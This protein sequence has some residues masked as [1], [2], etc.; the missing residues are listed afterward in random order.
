MTKPD[1]HATLQPWWG[2]CILAA[3]TMGRWHIGPLILWAQRLA[4]EWR[5]AWR[6]GE[7]LMQPVA[8]VEMSLPIEKPAA[9]M[10]VCRFSFRETGKPLRLVPA[11]ADRSVVVKPEV[12]L[13]IPGGEEITL[14]VS[15]PLWVQVF[16]GHG[17]MPLVEVPTLR[18]SDTWFGADTRH[19]EMCYA[20][21]TLAQ[22]R[23]EDIV[24]RPHRAITPVSI[25]NHASDTLAVERLSV[26]MPL[27]SLS[28][29]ERGHFWTQSVILERHTPRGE[30]ALQLGDMNLS[31]A[32][33]MQHIGGPRQMQEDQ[34][35][36]RALSRFF[37]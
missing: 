35:V 22:L 13:Y 32:T 26:P 24:P 27:L 37:G 18:P 19:G 33:R 7:E 34:T 2:E 21:R 36:L 28:V 16:V 20:S 5:I 12:P 31:G 17:S 8:Q 10:A 9:G 25:R 11:S 23:V 15:T 29:S 4:K 30:A 3:N 6:S 14:F 1:D